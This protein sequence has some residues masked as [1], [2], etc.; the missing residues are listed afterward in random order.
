[1][2]NV[3]SKE[4]LIKWPV[5]NW[6]IWY[7]IILYAKQRIN[8]K[9]RSTSEFNAQIAIWNLR[10]IA[11]PSSF[12]LQSKS[13][14]SFPEWVNFWTRG[15]NFLKLGKLCK[16][17]I[18]FRCFVV[19]KRNNT[20]TAEHGELI[21]K[22]SLP[23]ITLKHA[24]INSINIANEVLRSSKNSKHFASNSNSQN[25]RISQCMHWTTN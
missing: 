24:I 5:L 14:R 12:L 8:D 10:A 3:K 21:I 22:R 18:E 19:S 4:K 2:Q 20:G 11:T 16:S 17:E 7:H 9:G 15:I 6:S 25:K 23:Q 1:M 13:K